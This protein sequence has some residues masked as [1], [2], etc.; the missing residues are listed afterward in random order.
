MIYFSSR[1]FTFIF[2]FPRKFSVSSASKDFFSIEQYSDG[3]FSWLVY[4][5]SLQCYL[6]SVLNRERTYH[7]EF[8]RVTKKNI[9]LSLENF[10]RF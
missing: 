9:R 1:I 4:V 5:L 7:A 2:T 10:I 8:I 3:D 6:Y